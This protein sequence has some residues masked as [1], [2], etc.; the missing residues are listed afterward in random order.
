MRAIRTVKP[1]Y[2]GLC[3]ACGRSSEQLRI[4]GR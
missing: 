4:E 2:I 3:K 1:T